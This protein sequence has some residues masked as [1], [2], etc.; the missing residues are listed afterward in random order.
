MN[1]NTIVKPYQEKVFQ[2]DNIYCVY[3][4]S[5]I[6]DFSP[7]MLNS[8]YWLKQ[9]AVEGTAHGRGTTW[10]IHHQENHWVLRHYFR[11]GM[12]GKFNRDRYLFHSLASTRAARE[13]SLLAK[14]QALGL[15]APKP[16]AYRIV[17]HGRFYQADLL[18]VRIEEAK[19][20]VA[21][22][23]QQ[24]IKE[25]IWYKIGASIRQFH[26]KGI[27]HHDLNAHNILLDNEQQV[28]LI[29]F[30]RGEQRKVSRSWQESNMSRLLRSFRKEKKK[31][32]EFY[33]QE[34]NWQMLM[35][36]YQGQ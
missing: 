19:D 8:L 18:T 9:E 20:L 12:I 2:Q 36:G 13:F 17:R 35:S 10:F 3:D 22:L 26:D 11:G 1:P 30:D 7:E 34:G 16:V 14:L 15:P 25:E 32:P 5:Q 23:T 28:W 4:G 21:I 27:Y 6:D 31:L 33:W 29:D 24:S